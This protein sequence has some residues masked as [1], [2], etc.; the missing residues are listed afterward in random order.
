MDVLAH[1]IYEYHKKLRSLALYTFPISE[2]KHVENKLRA[3]QI[4]YVLQEVTPNKY[5]VFFGETSCVDV[6]R[7]IGD[8]PLNLY[9][10]EEDFMLGIMLGYDRLDQCRRYTQRA[11]SN[12]FIKVS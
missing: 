1:L 5:N 12:N 9:T 2:K 3:K 10:L 6:I 4:D 8:K 11:F 7:L